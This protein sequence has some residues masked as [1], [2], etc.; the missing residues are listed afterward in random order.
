MKVFKSIFI[1]ILIS[2]STHGAFTLQL[3][4][5]YTSD[6][7]DVTEFEYSKMNGALYIGAS[8]DKKD[9]LYLGQNVSLFTRTFSESGTET[10]VSVTEIGPKFIWYF[11]PER[12][13]HITLTWNPYAQG[14][15]KT[16]SDT[17]DISGWSYQI[18]FGYH[19]KISRVV[20]LGATINYHVL[21][22]SK[23]TDS[24][25]TESEVTQAYT[26]IMPMIELAFHFR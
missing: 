6:S 1:F 17:E 21:N 3:A 11:S 7:D 24:T 2:L 15:R 25:N 23:A 13:G 12:Q 16:S 26:N 20:R 10:E 9:Q 5:N 19:L 4:G 8:F 14:E 22:I 18:A